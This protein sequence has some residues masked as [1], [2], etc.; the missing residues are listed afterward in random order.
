MLIVSD[1]LRDE[2]IQGIIS[3]EDF[4]KSKIK[5]TVINIQADYRYM[6]L[7]YYVSMHAETQ[8]NRVIPTCANVIDAYN[9]AVLLARSKKKGIPIS[10]YIISNSAEEIIR[11]L[12]FPLVLFPLNPI[13]YDNVR[14]VDSKKK[15]IGAMKSL[16]LN[17]RYPVTA[18]TLV[19]RLETIKSIFGSTKTYETSSITKKCYEEFQIPLCKLYIQRTE[20]RSY[21]CSISPLQKPDLE[22]IDLKMISEKLQDMRELV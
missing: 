10:N 18:Q 2:K 22:P 12:E 7:G 3:S 14:I 21:L 17:F 13:S 16:G 4:L 6:K 8:G 11:E 1:I 19:G 20:E 5:D 15:L 9:N